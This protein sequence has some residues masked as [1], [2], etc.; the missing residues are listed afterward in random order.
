MGLS[1]TFPD[2]YAS[3]TTRPYDLTFGR[4]LGFLNDRI[5]TAGRVYAG[6]AER[7]SLNKSGAEK[8]CG[9]PG[10]PTTIT[11]QIDDIL[12]GNLLFHQFTWLSGLF[13]FP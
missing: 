1:Q 5:S 2:Q 9:R 11:S 13:R 10:T 8:L 7:N 4:R 3:C 12:V 6:S